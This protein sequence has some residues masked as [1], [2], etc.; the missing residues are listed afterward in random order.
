MGR[1]TQITPEW[2]EWIIENLQR[3]CQ[4]Q[5]IVEIMIDKGF[6]PM[7]ANAVVFHFSTSPTQRYAEA[8][9]GASDAN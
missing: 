5:S 7:F 3:G 6:D 8:E 4:A 9:K 2:Q 1:F